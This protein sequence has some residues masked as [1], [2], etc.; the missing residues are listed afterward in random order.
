MQS[1]VWNKERCVR[2]GHRFQRACEHACPFIISL[3][4]YLLHVFTYQENTK[5]KKT[6]TPALRINSLMEKAVL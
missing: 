5:R 4:K 3:N 6:L 1:S 2:S